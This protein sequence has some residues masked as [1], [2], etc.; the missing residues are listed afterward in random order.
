MSTFD[1][2]KVANVAC[3]KV[4]IFWHKLGTSNEVTVQHHGTY[5]VCWHAGKPLEFYVAY[6]WKPKLQIKPT[7]NNLQTGS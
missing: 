4:W 5:D 7:H 3:E 1:V 6:S 2:S